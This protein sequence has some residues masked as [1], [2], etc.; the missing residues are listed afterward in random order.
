MVE[1]CPENSFLGPTWDSFWNQV[2]LPHCTY[3]DSQHRIGWVVSGGCTILTTLITIYSV[4]THARNYH[5]RDEQRQIM[6]ILWMPAVYAIIAFFSYGFFRSY[7]YYLVVG[8]GMH[9]AVGISAFLLLLVESLSKRGT[10]GVGNRRRKQPLPFPLCCWRYRPTNPYFMDTIKCCVFQY[11]VIRLAENLVGVVAKY[12]NILCSNFWWS[13]KYAQFYLNIVDFITFSIAYY[14]LDLFYSLIHHKLHGRKPLAKCVS[15]Q[16]TFIIFLI[17]TFWTRLLLLGIMYDC[18]EL[19]TA[20]NITDGLSALATS[21]QMVFFAGL[22]QWSYNVSEYAN[23]GLGK[24]NIVQPLLDW[25][26]WSTA[27]LFSEIWSC[28]KF[29]VDSN[30]G[31]RNLRIP[32]STMDGYVPLAVASPLDISGVDMQLLN[33]AEIHES[34]FHQSENAVYEELRNFDNHNV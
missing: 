5:N 13:P 9:K 12:F 21:V 4:F 28:F 34:T 15:I 16:G 23:E 17:E 18:T 7:S 30:Q 27:D 10:E 11:I 29:L 2:R 20:T 33:T 3:G 6:R 19:W 31:G 25:C 8:A 22:M 24:T 32:R 26:S 1:I 14:G